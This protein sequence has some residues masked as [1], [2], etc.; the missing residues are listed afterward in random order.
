MPWPFDY[1]NGLP[2]KGSGNDPVQEP[3]RGQALDQG[4]PAAEP[5]RIHR[6]H[7]LVQ[8]HLVEP[9]PGASGESP[10]KTVSSFLVPS[11]PTA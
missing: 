8:G 2:H 4:E 9:E 7:R 6:I 5:Q 1:F 3:Q 10:Y 11:A